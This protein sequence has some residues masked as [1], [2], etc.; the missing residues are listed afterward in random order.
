MTCLTRKCAVSQSMA[1]EQCWFGLSAGSYKSCKQPHSKK[2]SMGRKSKNNPPSKGPIS[3]DDI[4][5]FSPVRVGTQ[6]PLFKSSNPTNSLQPSPSTS[7]GHPPL[8]RL[9]G[10]ESGVENRPPRSL[11][12]CMGSPKTQMSSVPTAVAILCDTKVEITSRVLVCLPL[13]Y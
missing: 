9:G 5:Y 1:P 7:K 10:K 2:A 4:F 12:P 8:L 11:T 6:A 13:W 3:S